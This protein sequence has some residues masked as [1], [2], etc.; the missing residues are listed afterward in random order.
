VDFD[1]TPEEAAYRAE[2]RAWLTE[3][4]KP[5][6]AQTARPVMLTDAYS[7]EEREHVRASKEWQALLYDEGWA[8][9]TWP[10][11]YGGRGGTVIEQIIFNQE[12]SHFAVPG[13]VFAQGIGMA[14]PTIIAHG[15]DAQKARFLRPMLRGDELWCQLF[16]E[17][18]AGSDLA[19][20]GTAAVADGEEWVVNGQKVWTSSAQ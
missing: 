16:S 8:G 9:I 15:T 4:A 12:Q 13:S 3:H 5:R 1:D 19:A 18:G 10:K 6:D 2:V 7:E 14:G 20:L 17:P 11:A